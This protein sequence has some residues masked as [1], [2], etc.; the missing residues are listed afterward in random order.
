LAVTAG[1]AACNRPSLATAR[2]GRGRAAAHKCT[3]STT[4]PAVRTTLAHS[5]RAVSEPWPLHDACDLESAAA[6]NLEQLQL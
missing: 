3:R 5:D 2:K 4:R 1:A 6:Y